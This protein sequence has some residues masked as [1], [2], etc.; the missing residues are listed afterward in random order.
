MPP[1]QEQEKTLA[2]ALRGW[3]RRGLI[4]AAIA[5]IVAIAVTQCGGPP[6]R[7]KAGLAAAAYQAGQFVV[8]ASASSSAFTDS[9]GFRVHSAEFVNKS[10]V[11][12]RTWLTN[13]SGCRPGYP[14]QYN[15]TGCY[16]PPRRGEFYRDGAVRKGNGSLTSNYSLVYCKQYA[17]GVIGDVYG[18]WNIGYGWGTDHLYH[19]T[20]Y[21]NAATAVLAH[22]VPHAPSHRGPLVPHL[23]D[24]NYGPWDWWNNNGGTP[25]FNLHAHANNGVITVANCCFQD[26]DL[27]DQAN[28]N[29]NGASQPTWLYELVGDSGWCIN[30]HGSDLEMWLNPCNSNNDD[31]R[32]TFLTGSGGGNLVVPV[33]CSNANGVTTYM[34]SEG[35]S[36]GAI[37]NCQAILNNADAD[38]AAFAS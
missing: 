8:T 11:F 29:I 12:T 4:L 23:P 38:W 9:C 36:N 26:W 24:T 34:S 10:P 15:R 3:R 7:H 31:Q 1:T 16:Y 35:N 17:H 21:H 27:V 30:F 33:T 6:G 28:R 32:F 20:K 19:Y 37:V 2:T 14:I 18:W 22:A 13:V 5:A 25:S